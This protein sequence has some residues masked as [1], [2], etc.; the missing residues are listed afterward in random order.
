MRRS[1][2][3]CNCVS[4]LMYDHCLRDEYISDVISSKILFGFIKNFNQDI[5]MKRSRTVHLHILLYM[6]QVCILLLYRNDLAYFHYILNGAVN[7]IDCKKVTA[8]YTAHV[9]Q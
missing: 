6:C 1:Y 9:Y 5:R 7:V 2:F 4:L 3:Q 8:M